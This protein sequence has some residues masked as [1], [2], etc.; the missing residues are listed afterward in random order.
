MPE[1]RVISFDVGGLIIDTIPALA[2][3]ALPD[4]SVDFLNQR[5]LEYTGL[6]LEQGLGLGGRAAFHPEDLPRLGDE[7]RAALAEGKQ[8]ETEARVR[9][10]D[11]EY[12]WFL[13]RAVPLRDETGNIVKW[14]GTNTDI[15]DRKQMEELRTAQA[16]QAAVRADVSAALSK[17][18]HLKEILRASAEAIVRH[19]DAVFARIWTLNK[20]ENVLELQASA[21]MYTHLDGPHSRVEIGKL[22]IGL[23]AQEKKPHLTNDVLNDQRISDKDWAQKEGIVAF[24]GYPLIIDDRVIGVMAMFARQRLSASTLDTLASIADAIAQGIER[25][26][27]AERIRQSEAYLSEAQRLSHTGSTGWKTSTG[28]ILWSEETFRIFE[29]DQTTKP[30]IE[31]ILQRVHPEDVDLVA[32]T[33]ERASQDRKDLNFEHRLLMPDGA[34]KYIHVLAH[35]ERDQSGDI[36]Y[37]GALMDITAR[38]R[39][40]DELRKSEKRYRDLLD[41]SPDAIYMGDAEGKLV[42][43]NPAG[44]ELLGCTAQEAVGMSMLETYL[45]EER[46]AFRER[47]EKLN[48]GARLRYERTFVRKD[49][50]QVP[51][52]VSASSGY[53]GYSL[54]LMRD[55]SERKHAETKLRRSEAYLAEAQR[56][57]RTGS[58]TVSADLTRT[59]YWSEEMFRIFGVPV[60]DTPPPR[61]DRRKFFTPED[62]ARILELFETIRHTKTTGDGEF[63]MVLGDGAQRTIRIVAHPALDASGNIVEFVGTTV[64]ITEQINARVELESALDEIKKSEDRLRLIID[65][66][67]TMSWGNQPDGSAEFLSRSWLAYTGLSLEESRN[68]GWTVVL[69]PEDSMALTEKWRAAVA[70]GKPFEAEARFRRADGEYRWCLCRAVPLRDEAGNILQWYGTTTDIEDRKRAEEVARKAQAELAHVTRVMTMGELV[71]SIAHEVNQPLGA[72]VTNGHACVRLLSREA[73]DLDKSREVVERMIKDGMRA[74]EVIKRIRELLHKTP[75]EKAPV[76]INETIEEVIALVHGDVLRSKVHLKSQLAAHL[77]PVLGDR[78]QLQQVILNLILNARDAMS[79]EHTRKLQITSRRN[80]TGAIVVAVRDTGHGFEIEDAKRIFEPFFTTKT[81]GMGLGLSI[82]RTIIE[83]HGGTLRAAKNEDKG[84]TIQFILPAGSGSAS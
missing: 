53:D 42:S 51:V 46:A 1:P 55:I 6:S 76:N 68:W 32:Q 43:A 60:A 78:I 62:W 39:V 5:W 70:T 12:R 2:W 8:F 48:A 47:V 9:R 81:G 18:A 41:L 67:P 69:H 28:E 33:I 75:V 30:T 80:T 72:I 24:A 77:P 10:T 25:K 52:E 14:Y 61:D 11:G 63:P 57:S 74:S 3:S 26:R 7:W 58:W 22:K 34:V 31:L 66:I 37:V 15:D 59:T 35:A 84:A 19:L 54:G 50:T 64:D 71:A 45:P 82:S 44:L 83:A 49:A 16:R 4:G 17:P 73:P 38:R 21:G 29:Y 13:I 27:T 36:E 40:E 79:G 65:T 20:D 23:I 56:L